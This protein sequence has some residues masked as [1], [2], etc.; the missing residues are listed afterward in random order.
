MLFLFVDF[1][2]PDKINNYYCRVATGFAVL[3]VIFGSPAFLSILF[4]PKPKKY[5]AIAGSVIAGLFLFFLISYALFISE[6]RT[7]YRSPY[8]LIAIVARFNGAAVGFIIS[9]LV[10]KNNGWE[11]VAKEVEIP[12]TY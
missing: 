12:E 9:Y 5:G 4:I 2:D 11:T 8:L 10:F 7:E 3:L 1:T 6:D